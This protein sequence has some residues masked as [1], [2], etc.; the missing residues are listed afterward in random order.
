MPWARERKQ[1]AT[2]AILNNQGE[3][4]NDTTM[5]FDTL[6]SS[7]NSA[8]NRRTNLTSMKEKLEPLPERGWNP[9]SRQELH[10]A[11]QSCAKNTAPGPDHVT[12]RLLKRFIKSRLEVGELIIK[13]ANASIN[14]V[15]E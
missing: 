4:C 8:N 12:W 11:L 14:Y 15:L 6:H 9:F 3:S 1:L 10:D 2:K 5:L 7:Y 13:V